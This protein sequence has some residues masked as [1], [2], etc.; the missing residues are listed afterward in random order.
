GF[1]LTLAGLVGL[2]SQIPGGEL[3]DRA[4][5]KRFIAA[6]GVSMVTL[7]ALVLA[8][9]PTFPL[10]LAAEILHGVTGGFL[11]P[12][13]AAISLGL[14]GHDALP[15][16]LGGNQRFAAIGGFL[17]HCSWGYSAISFQIVRSSLLRQRLPFRS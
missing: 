6:L 16:R 17:P 10:V 12:A 2:V 8:L 9:N 3:L 13:V 7:A 14:V 11:G 4:P 15:V 1:V 5:A